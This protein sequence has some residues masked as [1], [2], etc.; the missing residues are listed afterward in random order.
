MKAW[1]I[2][3]MSWAILYPSKKA[4]A[5]S[6]QANALNLLA[7]F[8][9]SLDLACGNGFT[10]ATMG[11][12]LGH[13]RVLAQTLHRLGAGPNLAHRPTWFYPSHPGRPQGPHRGSRSL[14]KSLD[15]R[16]PTHRE[17]PPGFHR[18]KKKKAPGESMDK[19]PWGHLET[20]ASQGIGAWA[21]P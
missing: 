4:A 9:A 12:H 18:S 11:A 6:G 17:C 20:W 10:P 8:G 19:S 15:Q 1:L 7:S 3:S 21:G 5:F 13:I 16:G 2:H 14:E